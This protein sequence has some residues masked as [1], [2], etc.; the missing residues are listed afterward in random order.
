LTYTSLHC[1]VVALFTVRDMLL[2]ARANVFAIEAGTAQTQSGAMPCGYCAL[3][4]GCAKGR[5][6]VAMRRRRSKLGV[7]T[8]KS[9]A[10]ISY[11]PT[12]LRRRLQQSTRSPEIL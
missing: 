5:V 8:T 11:W 1:D 2:T 9:I 7:G 4:A 6:A 10:H 12:R 3:R